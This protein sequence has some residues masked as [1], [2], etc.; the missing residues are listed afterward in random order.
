MMSTN[1]QVVIL[2]YGT[3]KRGDCRHGAMEGCRFIGPARTTADYTLYSCGSFPALVK[4]TDDFRTGVVGELYEAP[5]A[6]LDQHLDF[7]EGVPYLYRRGIVEIAE[8][9]TD[10]PNDAK[11]TEAVAYVYQR[12]I[13]ALEHIGTEWVVE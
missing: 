13:E 12:P 11:I 3:L 8:V 9:Q 5:T 1:D 7:I 2:V 4:A 10:N 6:L